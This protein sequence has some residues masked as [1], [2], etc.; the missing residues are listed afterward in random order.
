VYVPRQSSRVSSSA[1]ASGE[2]NAVVV[3]NDD[4]DSDSD[5]DDDDDYARRSYDLRT[6]SDIVRSAGRRA[7]GRRRRKFAQRNSQSR[8]V[9]N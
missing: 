9:S 8:R 3:V 4:S 2:N 6:G 7:S 5:D 1:G